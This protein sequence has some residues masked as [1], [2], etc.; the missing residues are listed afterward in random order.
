MSPRWDTDIDG[1]SRVII[2]KM[3]CEIWELTVTSSD[4]DRERCFRNFVSGCS[5]QQV[6][7]KGVCSSA[8]LCPVW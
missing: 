8:G 4:R 1:Q 5:Q 7:D 3:I 6:T 2:Q